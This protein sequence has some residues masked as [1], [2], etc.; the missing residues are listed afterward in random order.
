MLDFF[1]SLRNALPILTIIFIS[2]FFL[3]IVTRI[4]FAILIHFAM[5]KY[6]NLKSKRGYVKKKFKKYNKEEDELLKS[7]EDIPIAHSQARAD[8]LKNL[9]NNKVSQNYQL[10]HSEEQMLEKEEMSKGN[11]VDVVKPIGF[12]TS[13]ILGQ[14]LTFLIQSAQIINKRDK[15]GFWVSMIEAQEQAA[16]RQHGRSR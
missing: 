3:I 8:K 10:M 1:H 11:I 13:M 9:K 4:I 15:Q 5:K 14:K 12:W 16:G 7:R 2:V 6:A